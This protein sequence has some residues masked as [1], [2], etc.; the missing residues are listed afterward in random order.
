MKY[1]IVLGW[2][3]SFHGYVAYDF[4]KKVRM[5]G[6]QT[7]IGSRLF[8][9]RLVHWGPQPTYQQCVSCNQHN[10]TEIN[11][12]MGRRN[13]KRSSHGF[14]WFSHSSRAG[15]GTVGVGFHRGH[16]FQTAATNFQ[17]APPGFPQLCTLWGRKTWIPN[18]QIICFI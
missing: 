8:S 7:A 5:T 2:C 9:I 1:T 15:H 10:H 11:Q 4:Q 12:T 3:F 16:T 17:G 18:G 14:P 13:L 6:P